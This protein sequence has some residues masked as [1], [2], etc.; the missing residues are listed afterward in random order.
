MP[1]SLDPAFGKD[2]S[3]A[4]T[5]AVDWTAQTMF[6]VGDCVRISGC[7]CSEFG[8]SWPRPFRWLLKMAGRH[9]YDLEKFVE[10]AFYDLQEGVETMFGYKF[11][12]QKWNVT[13]VTANGFSTTK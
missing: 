5:V 9:S 3:A 10:M 1:M 8:R 7:L 13:R 2:E 12:P 6:Q 4:V 11:G